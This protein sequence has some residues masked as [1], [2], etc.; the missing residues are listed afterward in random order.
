MTEVSS[1]LNS[2]ILQSSIELNNNSPN[3]AN[4]LVLENYNSVQRSGRISVSSASSSNSDSS[5][6]AEVANLGV[7]A[8]EPKG[9]TNNQIAKVS[10]L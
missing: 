9:G 8:K 6:D 3:P 4:N 7:D 2:K 5:E 1:H 10:C